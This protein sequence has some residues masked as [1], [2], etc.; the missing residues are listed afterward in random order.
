MSTSARRWIPAATNPPLGGLARYLV[1]APVRHAQ[2]LVDPSPLEHPELSTDS[3]DDR[4]SD[5]AVLVRLQRPDQVTGATV[6]RLS[7]LELLARLSLHV[8]QSY[9]PLRFYYGGF[10]NH[11]RHRRAAVQT[12]QRQQHSEQ[13]E[14]QAS[15]SRK[16]GAAAG[17]I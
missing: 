11:A 8:P 10:S 2:L 9:Q 7:G 4:P 5:S 16:P 3:D 6:E 15:I 1:R 13:Q 14:P 17:P 12:P